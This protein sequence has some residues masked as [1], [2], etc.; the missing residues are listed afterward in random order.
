[1]KNIRNMKSRFGGR[2]YVGNRDSKRDTRNILYRPFLR[3]N[4]FLPYYEASH[5]GT[6]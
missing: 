3:N 1:M 2:K 4:T 6:P 5:L